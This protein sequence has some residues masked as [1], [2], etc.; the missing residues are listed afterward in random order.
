[1]HNSTGINLIDFSAICMEVF[2]TNILFQC[3]QFSANENLA[4]L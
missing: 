1:M 2:D 3:S 4:L